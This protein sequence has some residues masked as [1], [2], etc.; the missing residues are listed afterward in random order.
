MVAARP[1]Q[2]FAPRLVLAYETLS[3]TNWNAPY[4]A[5]AF[6]PNL[7]VDVTGYLDAKCEAMETYASQLKEPPHE[8]SLD[9]IRSLALLRGA[10]VN[11]NAA[12][13]FVIVRAV[14]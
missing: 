12:E 5:P 13:A 7:F 2:P 14:W 3:E 8:R 6:Q 1:H 9:A 11:T 4:L 10:A